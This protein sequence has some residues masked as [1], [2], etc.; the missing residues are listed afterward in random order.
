MKKENKY[1]RG[2]IMRRAWVYVKKM[3][4]T[5]SDALKRAWAE[6]KALKSPE[7]LKQSYDVIKNLLKKPLGFTSASIL[8][9]TTIKGE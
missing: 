3:L 9:Y 4:A 1:D 7:A 5:F 6:A 8:N 2:S